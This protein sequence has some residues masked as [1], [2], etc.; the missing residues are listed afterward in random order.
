VLV[1]SESE[2]LAALEARADALRQKDVRVSALG[3]Q[4]MNTVALSYLAAK[5]GGSS[6]VATN[7]GELTD[8]FASEAAPMPPDGPQAVVLVIDR[9]GSMSGA[10]L[11]AAKESARMVAE[12]LSPN[13]TI[14]V[15][16]FDSE[17]S[18]LV[19]PQRA[20]NRMRISAEITRVQT[21]GGT[22]IYPGLK[23]AFQILQGVNAYRK[24]V[25]LLTDGEAPSDGIAELVQDM[26]AARITVTCV[27]V[28]GADRNLL[29]M[30]ADAGDGRLYLVEDIGALPRIFMTETKARR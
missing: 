5:G 16:G 2:G 11:E 29:S 18:V 20:S 26:R 14:A 9:S 22:N 15:V 10:K 3:Y 12:V 27:G 19:Q 30:I 8:A 23:E 24:H 4:G 6:F 21:G 7:R 17:A 1:V 25:I 28:Q 13:D